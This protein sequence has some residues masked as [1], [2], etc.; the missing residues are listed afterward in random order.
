MD[1]IWPLSRSSVFA[2]I[3]LVITPSLTE[4]TLSAILWS[5]G[6]ETIG[7]MVFSLH[8]E[9]KVLTTAALSV[10]VL[11]AVFVANFVTRRLSGGKVEF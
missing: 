2:I 6:N 1:V 10:L 11:I 9:G 8:Q 5:V 7:V 4:L 3:F